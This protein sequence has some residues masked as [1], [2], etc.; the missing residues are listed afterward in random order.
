MENFNTFMAGKLGKPQL[1][2]LDS[3]PSR[4]QSLGDMSRDLPVGSNDS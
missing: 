4:S 3:Q 2:Y 1:L